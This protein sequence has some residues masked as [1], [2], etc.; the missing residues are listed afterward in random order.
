ME[1]N[2]EIENNKIKSQ[3]LNFLIGCYFGQSEDLLVAAIDRAYVDMASHT[4]KFEDVKGKWECR[5]NASEK[6]YHYINNFKNTIDF[7]KWHENLIRE[8]IGCYSENKISI[9]Q[10]QK[11]LNM[12]IKYLYVFNVL[13]DYN[14]RINDS[15]RKV[16]EK[17]KDFYAPVDS[18][19]LKKIDYSDEV[20]SK[21][22]DKEYSEVIKKIKEDVKVE[23]CESSFMWEFFNW[24]K[25]KKSANTQ[26][27]SK[28]YAYHLKKLNS[29]KCEANGYC[30]SWKKTNFPEKEK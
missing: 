23:K 19:V 1:D 7:K 10:A 13:M 9:G 4:L 6:I 15:V 12:T 26:L 16:M 8:I 24:E 5:L 30:D 21:L 18:F 25:F 2:F 22:N 27:D 11:W 17:S 3:A 28:S 29:E 14:T 20:W